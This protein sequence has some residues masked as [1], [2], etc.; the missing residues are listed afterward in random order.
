L[1]AGYARGGGIALPVRPG[2][3]FSR[4]GPPVASRFPAVL[5]LAI[6]AHKSAMDAEA[7]AWGLLETEKVNWT[8]AYKRS[9]RELARLY[10]KDPKKANAYF[11]PPTRH[12][13]AKDE[14]VVT[15]AAAKAVPAAS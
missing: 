10:Y 9:Y 6:D 5:P 2:A 4:G 15:P 13:K 14:E 11:K 7:Q 12:R 8:D 3:P 1:K